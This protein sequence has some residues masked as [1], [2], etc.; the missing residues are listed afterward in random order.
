MVTRFTPWDMMG[1]GKSGEELDQVQ[2]IAFYASKGLELPYVYL[3]GMEE[4]LLPYQS[5]IDEDNIDEERRLVY[6]GITRVQEELAFTFCRERRQYGRL[7]CSE[8]SRFLFELPQGDLIR[9]Q[10]RKIISV[11]EC[12]HKG[13]VN[14]VSIKA[15]LA[16]AKKD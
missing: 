3:V 12:M 1:R 10:E 16:E 11:E 14:V 15:V 5:S 8:P 7:V 4:G 13:Q 9:E 6:A 2:L